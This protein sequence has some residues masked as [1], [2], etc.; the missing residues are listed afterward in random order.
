[1][2]QLFKV[3]VIVIAAFLVGVIVLVVGRMAIY[4]IHAYEQGLTVE[5]SEM[6]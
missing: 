4:K 1:V 2:D 3:A 6:E 5:K